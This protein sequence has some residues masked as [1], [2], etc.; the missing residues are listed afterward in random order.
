MP[1]LIEGAADGKGLGH[2]FLRHVVRCRALVLVVDLSAEDPAADLAALR[3]ELG[4]YDPALAARPAVVV[5]TKTDLVDD[6]RERADALGGEVVVVSAVT[7][8][9][10]DDLLDRLGLLAREAAAAEPPRRPT[11]VLRP[12]RPHFAVTRRGGVWEVHGPKV[13]RWVMEADLDDEDEVARLQARFKKEGIDRALAAQGARPGDEVSIHGK[14]FEF[15]PDPAA[16]PDRAGTD[17][18]ERAD[19]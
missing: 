17:D 11:V 3:A 5:G 18:D 7:G 4:A 1:G 12:G 13:E 6:A 2:R 10:V 9:G 14:A 15:Q 8:E 16:Q 19:A